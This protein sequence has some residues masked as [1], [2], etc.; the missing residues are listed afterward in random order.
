MQ[1]TNPRTKVWNRPPEFDSIKKHK[2]LVSDE[3]CVVNPVTKEEETH[4]VNTY[5]EE[6]EIDSHLRAS[7]FSLE[8]QIRAGVQLKDCGKYF[9]PENPEQYTELVAQLSDQINAQIAKENVKHE[10]VSEPAS[11]PVIESALNA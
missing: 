3:V 9:T 2:I 10:P 5:K 11:E 6:S 4:I 8:V 7:D 1:K